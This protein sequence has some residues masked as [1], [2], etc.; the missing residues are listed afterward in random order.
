[1]PSR[2]SVERHDEQRFATIAEPL[3]LARASPE[4]YRAMILTA[5]LAGLRQG[6]LLALRRGDVDL[7]VPA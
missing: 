7:R 2:G 3:E 5:G 4:R 6:E 1:M